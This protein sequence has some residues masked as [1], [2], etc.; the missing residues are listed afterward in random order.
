M[1]Q[2]NLELTLKEE[3]AS[4]KA[5][6]GCKNQEFENLNKKFAEKFGTE[7]KIGIGINSG[8][9]VAGNM[10]SEDRIEYSVTG[11]TVNTGKRIEGITRD[12]P[13][14]VL[15]S[16]NVY[17]EVEHLIEVEAFEPLFVK[18]KKEKISVYKVV[19]V[20]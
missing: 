16:Q 7:I 18:G 13:N 20:K 4:L 1:S 12:F 14:S 3:I 6:I 2:D 19:G 9:V 17:D 10:G 5:I 11:D 8:E 15:I